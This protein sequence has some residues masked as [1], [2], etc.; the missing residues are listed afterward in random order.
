MIGFKY[1]RLSIFLNPMN[2]KIA[3][4]IAVIIVIAGGWY[5]LQET[6][7]DIPSAITTTP[8]VTVIY[9]DQGFSP[10]S[11]TVPL[12]TTVTFVNQSGGSMWVASAMHPTHVVYS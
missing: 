7:V 11:V 12:G 8:G 6:P 9:T 3:G 2:E 5:L 4:I 10:L 1:V